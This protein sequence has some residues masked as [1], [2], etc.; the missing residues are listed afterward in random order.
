MQNGAESD[1]LEMEEDNDNGREDESGKCRNFDEDVGKG[2][3]ASWGGAGG[4]G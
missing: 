4:S 1:S 2:S 3:A